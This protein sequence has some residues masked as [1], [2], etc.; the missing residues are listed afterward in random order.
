M[1]T[2]Y[3]SK[4]FNLL[5]LVRSVN[6][7]WSLLG[8]VA[9]IDLVWLTSGGW[10][11][12]PAGLLFRVSI[13][14]VLCAPLLFKRYRRNDKLRNLGEAIAFSLIFATAGEILSYLVVS[15]NFPLID[16][17]LAAAD[18]SLGFDWGSYYLWAT[19]HPLYSHVIH[20]A[21]EGMGSQLWIVV[22]YLCF[23]KRFSRLSEFLDLSASLLILTIFV[24]LFFPAEG[25]SK[26]YGS[27]YHADVS[28]MFHFELLRSGVMK[29]IDL[30]AVQGLISIPSYHTVMGILLCWA[31]RGSKLCLVAILMNSAM[32]LATP[33]VGGHYFLDLAAG[34]IVTVAGILMR[35]Y[36]T[37]KKTVHGENRSLI[38]T[39]ASPNM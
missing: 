29:M 27:H 12:R 2:A 20:A 31:V 23:T 38:G 39:E 19:N 35:R 37:L 21:Y 36:F 33:T 26:F 6:F 8:I 10:T 13:G 5:P 15:T 14:V 3:Q 11:V 16:V 9:A 25:A 28:G 17:F 32:L 24:S 22:I 7:R 4:Y 30:S 1:G 34:A 18:N